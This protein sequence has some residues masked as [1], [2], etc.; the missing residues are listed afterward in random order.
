VTALTKNPKPTLESLLENQ[1]IVT[2]KKLIER[3]KEVEQEAQRQK[4]LIEE[5]IDF[6]RRNRRK[7]NP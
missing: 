5:A 3:R 7:R 6:E 1:Q 2:G 4:A